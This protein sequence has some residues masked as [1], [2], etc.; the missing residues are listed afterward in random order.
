MTK[1]YKINKCVIDVE[2][3]DTSKRIAEQISEM[4]SVENAKVK[5]TVNINAEEKLNVSYVKRKDIFQETVEL[6]NKNRVVQKRKI[7]QPFSNDKIM[8]RFLVNLKENFYLKQM[9][10]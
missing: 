7:K 2:I 8:R 6:I 9:R 3:K 10:I 4:F 1:I 5:D